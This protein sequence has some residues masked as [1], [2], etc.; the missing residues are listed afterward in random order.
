MEIKNFGIREKIIGGFLILIIIFGLNGVFNL[1]AINNSQRA[2]WEILK[3]KDPSLQNLN[4]F[5]FEVLQSIHNTSGLVYGYSPVQAD[6]SSDIDYISDLHKLKKDLLANRVFWEEDESKE[7]LKDVM[8]NADK[9]IALETTIINNYKTNLSDSLV[10]ERFEA[11]VIPIASKIIE[12]T[13]IIIKIKETEKE[14]DEFMM[15]EFF[16]SLKNGLFISGILII[17]VCVVISVYTS[18][19]V[20]NQI[21]KIGEVTE[22]LS[23]GLHP[24]PIQNIKND[25]VGKMAKGINTL[26]EGLKETS[27]FAENIGKGNFEAEFSPLSSQDVLGNSLI[28]MRNNL[29]KVSEEDKIRNWANE[30][31]ARFNDLLRNNYNDRT[32]FAYT[33]LSSL[34]KYLDVNQGMFLVCQVENEEEYIEEIA[35]YAWNRRKFGKTRYLKGEGL[36]GQ[37]WVEQEHIFMSE[38]PEDYVQIKSGIGLAMPRSVIV[39]PLKY[40]EEIYGIIELASFKV[41]AGYE[42]DFLLKISENIAASLSNS[43]TAEKMK[44]LLDETQVKSQQ[45]REQEEQMRQNLEE[46]GATQEDMMRRE[47]EMSQQLK[48]LN[49]ENDILREK[50]NGLE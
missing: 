30:G 20:L 31:N 2:L 44:K 33:I 17:V 25:E 49:Q 19:T 36:A 9:L 50:M 27:E 14:K 4:Q 12:Q 46:L 13:D 29:K 23:K 7:L 37:A 1:S 40:N 22:D 43:M 42:I 5:R 34:V 18:N 8:N 21:K 39:F 15:T 47:M 6:K 16:G 10:S 3:E 45:L 26:I 28:E 35:S 24:E 48:V 41:F 32:E 11:T 38:V